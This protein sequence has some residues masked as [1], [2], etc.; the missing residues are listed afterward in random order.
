MVKIHLSNKDFLA[1]KLT[2]FLSQRKH[3]G[4]H[5]KHLKLSKVLLMIIHNMFSSRNKTNTVDSCYLE[6][7]GTH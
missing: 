4:T 5:Y 3:V 1:Q 6:F 2:V 7:Q